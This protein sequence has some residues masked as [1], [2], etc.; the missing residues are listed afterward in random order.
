MSRWKIWLKFIRIH[1]ACL[2]MSGCLLGVYFAI[3]ADISKLP[4]YLLFAI[5]ALLFHAS[6]FG[7]N[8]VMDYK[9]DV[10]DPNKKHFPLVTGE[11]DL[12]TANKFIWI[13]TAFAAG[14]GFVL[15]NGRIL[16]IAAMTLGFT[17]SIAYNYAN[18]IYPRISP[19]LIAGGFTAMPFIGYFSF[20]YDYNTGFALLVK[21][22]VVLLLYQIAVEGFA[23]DFLVP[24]KNLLIDLGAKVGKDGILRW[25][26]TARLFAWKLHIFK[27]VLIT[28]MFYY[29]GHFW[30]CF[31]DIGGYCWVGFLSD[32]GPA[33]FFII[34][35]TYFVWQMTRDQQFNNAKIV[36]QASWI[37]VFSYWAMVAA[38]FSVLDL[39]WWLFIF[40]PF[41]WF[42]IINKLTWS[43]TTA[44]KV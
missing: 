43:T 39:L 10:V 44:P 9:W 17:W 4:I 33:V 14:Y 36:Q 32:R 42:V 7:M 20:T 23:K 2:T 30:Y 31:I 15:C 11:I 21:Y 38:I 27:I 26:F 25:S 22:S 6:G 1:T 19:I 40:S 3:G 35:V 24:Q 18:K 41:I 28:W 8:N 29:F 34:I 5:F 16:A 37:E 13:L 12:K